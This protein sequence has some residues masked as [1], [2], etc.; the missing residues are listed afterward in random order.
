MIIKAKSLKYHRKIPELCGMPY[1]LHKRGCPNFNKKEGCPMGAYPIYDLIKTDKSIYLIFVDFDLE[2]HRRKLKK[3]YPRWS[4]R[5]LSCV[6]YWQPK[7]RKQLKKEIDRF[8]EERKNN[9]DSYLLTT[10]PEA[11]GV[12]VSVMMREVGFPLTW[13]Y[14]LKKVYQVA[15]AGEIK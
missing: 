7:L 2:A 12:N 4:I 8:F 13:K 10:I 3:K 1:P 6:L 11:H 14:P 15:I 9:Q 5:Q